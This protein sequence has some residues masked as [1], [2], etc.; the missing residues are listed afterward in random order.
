TL[1]WTAPFVPDGSALSGGSTTGSSSSGS[2]SAPASGSAPAVTVS[3]P[4]T[5]AWQLAGT[6]A[7]GSSPGGAAAVTPFAF[8]ASSYH[9]QIAR[10]AAFSNIV[11]DTTTSTTSFTVGFDL[12]IAT[13]YFWRVTATNAC[14]T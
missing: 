14:G 13:Q 12:A 3:K 2:F 6:T 5:F 4:G 7:P 1:S 10:D 9:L 11:V 8:G